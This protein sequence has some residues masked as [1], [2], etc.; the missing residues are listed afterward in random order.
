MQKKIFFKLHYWLTRNIARVLLLIPLALST[1][2]VEENSRALK[3]T[4]VNG[5]EGWE[6]PLVNDLGKWFHLNG[7]PENERR[8]SFKGIFLAKL[9]FQI[10]SQIVSSLNFI[11]RSTQTFEIWLTFKLVCSNLFSTLIGHF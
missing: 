1:F 10:T 3:L 8:W 11:L 4:P 6:Y 2:K 7:K 9:F 5:R